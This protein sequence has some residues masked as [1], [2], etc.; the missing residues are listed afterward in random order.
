MPGVTDWYQAWTSGRRL[1]RLANNEHRHAWIREILRTGG[2]NLSIL[3]TII[4]GT[5]LEEILYRMIALL[6]PITGEAFVLNMV[7]II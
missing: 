6:I 5:P 7:V 3:D 1:P 2:A 4:F